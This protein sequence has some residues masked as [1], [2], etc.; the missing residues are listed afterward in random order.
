[1]VVTILG[2]LGAMA[3]PKFADLQD[4]AELN[5]IRYIAA[6]FRQSVKLVQLT[7][8]TQGYS[9]RVQNLPNFGA[10]D[11]DTNNLGFPIGTDKGNA[12]E[13]IGRGGN[14]CVGVWNGILTAPPSVANGNNNSDFRSY[15]HTGNRVCSY[16]YRL[17]GDTGNR[18]TSLIV[19]RYDSRD[20]S[21]VVCG[22]SPELSAC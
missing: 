9:T 17:N 20:G 5:Q 21:V 7:F 8:N 18:N 1:M 11:V 10:G 12:N 15:R 6:S 2:V 14:G 4:D 3:F 13:S 22:R 19:I 16:A